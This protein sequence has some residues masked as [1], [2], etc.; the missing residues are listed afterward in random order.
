MFEGSEFVS[1]TS[2]RSFLA[3]SLLNTLSKTPGKP[4][5]NLMVFVVYNV[6]SNEIVNLT[7]GMNKETSLSRRSALGNWQDALMP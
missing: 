1:K 2:F 6:K 7:S 4:L 3:G 5:P